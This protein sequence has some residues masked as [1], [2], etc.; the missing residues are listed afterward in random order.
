MVTVPPRPLL[1]HRVG[2]GQAVRQL[3]RLEKRLT[4]LL[5]AHTWGDLDDA[6][7]RAQRD[8]ARLALAQLPDGDILVAFDRNRRVMSDMAANVAAANP[9]Q[10]RQLVGL[11]VERVVAA[12][13]AVDPGA[14]TWTPP[15]RPFSRVP[16]SAW[17]WSPRADS[18]RRRAP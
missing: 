8:E 17:L 9:A 5:A 6:T 14:I 3:A 2:H 1:T 12:D 7:Y 16:A 10:R 4:R 13:R 18:N 11:L 15:A